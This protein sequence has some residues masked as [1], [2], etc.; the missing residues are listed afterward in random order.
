MTRQALRRALVDARSFEEQTEK[1]L[2]GLNLTAFDPLRKC[3][4]LKAIRL[5]RP[6]NGAVSTYSLLPSSLYNRT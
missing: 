6:E 2:L 4:E 3:C 5:I 1:K